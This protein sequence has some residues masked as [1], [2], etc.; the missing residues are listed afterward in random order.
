M[1]KKRSLSQEEPVYKTKRKE[2]TL[3]VLMRPQWKSTAWMKDILKEFTN[4]GNLVVDACDE[5]FSVT[6][7]CVIL[8]VD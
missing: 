7:A 3:K 5:T 6:K 2:P 1:F 4:P 8:P